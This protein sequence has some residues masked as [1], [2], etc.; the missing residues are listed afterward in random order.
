MKI[1]QSSWIRNHLHSRSLSI[2]VSQSKPTPSS[3]VQHL[4]VRS[5][6]GPQLADASSP[7]SSIN[8]AITTNIMS[9][10]RSTLLSTSTSKPSSQLRKF[11]FLQLPGEIRNKIYDHLFGH[12]RVRI[13]GNHPE[14][15]MKE[16]LDVWKRAKRKSKDAAIPK[17]LK[18]RY[19]LRCDFEKGLRSYT[20]RPCRR[21]LVA[22][23]L[24]GV[25]RTVHDEAIPYLYSRMF[26]H[27]E[28]TKCLA[29]FLNGAS[30]QGLAYIRKLE[31]L[32]IGYGEP[33]LSNARPYKRAH[34]AKWL[35]ACEAISE[36]MTRLQYLRMDIQ[37]CD[38]PT[39][40][41]MTASWVR[42]LMS[43]KGEN[44]LNQV[45]IFLRCNG[46][47]DDLL[48]AFAT[49]LELEMM[50]PEARRLRKIQLEQGAIRRLQKFVIKPPALPKATKCLRIILPTATN[51]IKQK[52]TPMPTLKGQHLTGY[53]R[54]LLPA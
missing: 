16:S 46:F 39:Q 19:R 18:P 45:H 22:T 11:K 54:P 2:T 21:S 50:S 53:W 34:D 20:S 42:P 14:K 40:L 41:N 5:N 10:S 8:V 17:P 3:R 35:G 36:K 47:K 24:L 33:Q 44:G 51:S 49:R 26:N 4:C 48:A 13:R 37:I 7:H 31:I 43:M 15:E 30:P 25:C 52:T 28:S 1:T 29:R 12:Y 6:P 23:E 38:W 9:V 27:F 32:H